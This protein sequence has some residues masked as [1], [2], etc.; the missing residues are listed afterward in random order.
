MV[1]WEIDWGLIGDLS[2]NNS[3]TFHRRES[4]SRRAQS[5]DS[6]LPFGCDCAC[7]KVSDE[8]RRGVIGKQLIRAAAGVAGNYR[9]ACRARSHTEFTAKI[10]IVLDEA[11]RIRAVVECRPRRANRHVAARRTSSSRGDGTQSCNSAIL[12]FCNVSVCMR[13]SPPLPSRPGRWR[14]PALRPIRSDYQ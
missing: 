11:R 10:G 4:K 7:E 12:P 9:S 14:S 5:A 6:S 1:D 13:S 8:R 2:W 3:C